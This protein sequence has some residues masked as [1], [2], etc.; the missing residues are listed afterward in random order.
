M[1]IEKEENSELGAE[2]YMHTRA[3]LNDSGLLEAETTIGTRTK[4]GGWNGGVTV[5]FEDA[6]HLA[7][8]G[9]TEEHVWGVD[10]RAVGQS[11]RT[12]PWSENIDMAMVARTASLRILH[13]YQPNFQA[14]NN[15]VSHLK[16]VAR[17]IEE[18]IADLK[19]NGL[20]S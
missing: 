10:G 12:V 9:T 11:E 5:L 18:V 14:I 15:I 17:N 6:S 19:S 7:V 8:G 1:T 20:I 16:V 2:H 3:R 13:S 4:A